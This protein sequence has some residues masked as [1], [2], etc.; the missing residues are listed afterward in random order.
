M[1]VPTTTTVL[2]VILM[3]ALISHAAAIAEHTILLILADMIHIIALGMWIGGLIVLLLGL[4]PLFRQQPEQYK[5][6][7]LSAGAHLA[8]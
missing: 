3:Q 7:I 5:P 1:A 4:F 8:A 6:I 2:G